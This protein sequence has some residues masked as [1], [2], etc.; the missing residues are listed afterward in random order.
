MLDLMLTNRRRVASYFRCGTM[1]LA[2]RNSDPRQHLS[3]SLAPDKAC[4]QAGSPPR[5]NEAAPHQFRRLREKLRRLATRG[6]PHAWPRPQFREALCRVHG[7]AEEDHPHSSGWLQSRLILP[8]RS[9]PW[10]LRPGIEGRR[11][12]RLMVTNS[13]LIG[14]MFEHPCCR[15]GCSISDLRSPLLQLD[16]ELRLQSLA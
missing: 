16:S 5:A 1:R 13:I 15:R 3:S 12:R 14:P 10:S 8:R 7:Q 6:E 4:A 11:R 2:S 9:L